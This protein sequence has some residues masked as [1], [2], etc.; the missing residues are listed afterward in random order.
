MVTEQKKRKREEGVKDDNQDMGED[1]VFQIE[2][3]LLKII[4]IN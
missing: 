3:K 2:S 4:K 1:D